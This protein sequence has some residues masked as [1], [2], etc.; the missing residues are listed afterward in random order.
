MMPRR[1]S[2][3]ASVAAARAAN[4][5]RDKPTPYAI[6]PGF[7]APPLHAGGCLWIEREDFVEMIRAGEDP[8]CGARTVPGE[9]YCRKHR[10]RAFTGSRP[11][12]RIPFGA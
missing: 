4:L 10:D 2:Q 12:P 3:P 11:F 6:S 7:M 1:L 9:V 5:V 8:H